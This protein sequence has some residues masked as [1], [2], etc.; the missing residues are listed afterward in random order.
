MWPISFITESYQNNLF[1]EYPVFVRNNY[2]VIKNS[3]IPD[4]YQDNFQ[5]ETLIDK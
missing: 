2:I 1:R 3:P 5:T 4:L